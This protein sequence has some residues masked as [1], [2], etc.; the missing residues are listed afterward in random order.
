MGISHG[1]THGFRVVQAQG[2]D[3]NPQGCLALS[4]A[5]QRAPPDNITKI[6]PKRLATHVTFIEN[7]VLKPDKKILETV[8]TWVHEFYNE[9]TL[10][11]LLE[12]IRI[13][14]IKRKK[15]LLGSL[16]GVAQGNRLSLIHISEPTR[17]AEI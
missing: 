16:I 13:L 8:P 11:E 14:K 6:H 1:Y 5:K 15:F 2:K 17:Q 7:L 12:L 4:A 9:D 3:Q 10:A